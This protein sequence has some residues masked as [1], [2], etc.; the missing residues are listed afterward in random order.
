MGILGKLGKKTWLPF[1]KNRKQLKQHPVASW[2][3]GR[4]PAANS[5]PLWAPERRSREATMQACVFSI[6]QGRPAAFFPFAQWLSAL[7]RCTCTKAWLSVCT[8]SQSVGVWQRMGEKSYVCVCV[9]VWSDVLSPDF[10]GAVKSLWLCWFRLEFCL[11]VAGKTAL[12]T[13]ASCYYLGTSSAGDETEMFSVSSESEKERG[14][15]NL[16][17]EDAGG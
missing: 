2:Y 8:C 4:E 14:L 1:F 6:H 16:R 3:L 17:R 15:R 10:S 11:L 9:S 7:N 12:G 13:K 5:R